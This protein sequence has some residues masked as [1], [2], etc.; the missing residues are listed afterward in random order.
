MKYL[1][2]V[3]LI[4]G[5]RMVCKPYLTGDVLIIDNNN[6]INVLNLQGGEAVTFDVIN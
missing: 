3:N 1:P 2:Y 4:K 5:L 6:L